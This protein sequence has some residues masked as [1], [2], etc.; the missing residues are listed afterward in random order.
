MTMRR[1]MILVLLAGGMLP[2]MASGQYVYNPSDFATEV[3]EYV[4]G[5]GIL[6]DWLTGLPFNN[7]ATALGRPTVDT[8]GD[9]TAGP[10]NEP[11][12]VIP[13][14]PPSRPTEVVTVGNGGRLVL[15]FE[16]PVRNDPNNPYGMDLI[17][18]GNSLMNRGD[19]SYWTR[20]TDPAAFTINGS[21]G[22]NEHG[23]V[24]VSQDGVT[25]HTFSGVYADGFAPT[26]GRVYDPAN[27]DAAAFAGNLWWGG[28]TD[29]TL[30]FTPGVSYADFQ[31]KTLA[32]IC[33]DYYGQSAGGT[34]FDLAWLGVAG[35]D[36]IQYVRIEDAAGGTLTT[37]VDAV[38]DV[39]PAFVPRGDLDKDGVVGAWDIGLLQRHVG[40]AAY[41]LGYDLNG[42][43][44]AS[45]ADVDVLVQE[46]LGTRFG[47]TDLNRRVDLDDLTI[48][49]TFYGQPGSY[50][51]REGDFNGD[52]I[53]DL[54]DLTT[55]GTFY[56]WRPSGPTPLPEPATLGLLGL[57]AL[58]LLRRRR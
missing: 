49:G 9:G 45:A 1:W 53:V 35:L 29:P 55:L 24:S 15:K 42:D 28:A 50:S 2:G 44:A 21:T 32:Q 3:H 16:K 41:G 8:V 6:N 43:G 57:G 25:W 58:P 33:T 47:D 36:W 40:E 4:P 51:W 34:A 17:V 56:G 31:Y 48:V 10:P 39:A 19:A 13:V 26:L 22:S 30:P 7:A 52:G 20:S 11:A 38:A 18:F 23:P 14:Y 5:T 37:E 12:P 46:I 54:D 27:Y